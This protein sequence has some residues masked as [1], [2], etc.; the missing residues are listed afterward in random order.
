MTISSELPKWQ[1]QVTKY[2]W[3]V[4]SICLWG[5]SVVFILKHASDL[6]RKIYQR[7]GGCIF[8]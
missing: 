7:T 2:Y 3:E 5:W 4:N 1:T 6:Y 8:F